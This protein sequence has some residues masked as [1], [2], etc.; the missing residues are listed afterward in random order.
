MSLIEKESITHSGL[1]NEACHR[2]CAP[3]KFLR[4]TFFCTSK[5]DI[6]LLRLVVFCTPIRPAIEL[7]LRA[8]KWIFYWEVLQNFICNYFFFFKTLMDGCYKISNLISRIP[9]RAS[10][11]ITE[12]KEI[13]KKLVTVAKCHWCQINKDKS[14]ISH[15]CSI[16]SKRQENITFCGINADTKTSMTRFP[17][18]LY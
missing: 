9:I 5:M 2:T 8:P 1:L 14:C 6:N 3:P 18:D 16:V 17:N 15:K 4:H 7:G 12:K 13:S 11:Q 10:G